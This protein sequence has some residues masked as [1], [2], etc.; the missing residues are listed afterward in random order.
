MARINNGTIR[1]DSIIQFTEGDGVIIVITRKIKIVTTINGI[2]ENS[3]ILIKSNN[4]LV[5]TIPKLV[6]S[7]IPTKSDVKNIKTNNR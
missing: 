1:G 5:N 2:P 4:L 6:P 7:R 3:K